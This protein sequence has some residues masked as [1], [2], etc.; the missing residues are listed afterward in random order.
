MK[1]IILYLLLTTILFSEEYALKEVW[2]LTDINETIKT[3]YG[4]DIRLKTDDK[5]S[6]IVP[7]LAENPFLIPLTIKSAI[8]LKSIAILQKV[9]DNKN[10]IAFIKTPSDSNLL[11]RLRLNL[12]QGIFLGEIIVIFEGI[13]GKFYLD[14]KTVR[15]SQRCCFGCGDENLSKLILKKKKELFQIENT[16]EKI[17]LRVK[18]KNIK[19]LLRLPIVNKKESKKYNLPLNYIK[20]IRCEQD[21]NILMEIYMNHYSYLMKFSSTE[22]VNDKHID[23][24]IGTNIGMEYVIE[25]F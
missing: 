25:N 3:L 15:A 18:N 19:F 14:K 20:Y 17:R 8:S 4:K 24:F 16:S 23:F 7:A 1:K 11:Y 6:L 22:F 5:V 2:K 21:K 10:L 12:E 13:D 9:K